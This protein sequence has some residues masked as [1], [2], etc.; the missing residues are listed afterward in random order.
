MNGATK[1]PM[2]IITLCVS[3]TWISTSCNAELEVLIHFFECRDKGIIKNLQ[4]RLRAF[5]DG[6]EDRGLKFVETR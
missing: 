5:F 1:H 6:R 4:P 2:G 3:E